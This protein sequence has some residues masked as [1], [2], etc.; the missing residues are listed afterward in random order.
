MNPTPHTHRPRV[1]VSPC[2]RDRDGHPGYWIDGKYID[3]I[4]LAEAEPWLVPGC[5]AEDLPE[6]LSRADGLLLTGSESNVHPS[7]FGEAPLDPLQL[8]DPARD[9]W[10]LRAAPLAIEMGVPL[11]GV[12]RGLQE[13]NVALGGSLHQDLRQ[14]EGAARHLLDDAPDADA[15]YGPVHRITLPPGGL[16]HQWLQRDHVEVNSIH[17][18]GVQRLAPGLRVEAL[19][20]DGLVEAFSAPGAS[21]FTLA[22]QWHPEWRPAE[23]GFSMVLWRAFGAACQQRQQGRNAHKPSTSPSWSTTNN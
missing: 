10:T 7:H 3:A 22:V 20:P 14:R 13:I 2:L 6:L 1:L 9:A 23:N 17:L 15:L 19:A 11:L 16:L 12:C 8:L 18:Q 21:A 4:R 5:G